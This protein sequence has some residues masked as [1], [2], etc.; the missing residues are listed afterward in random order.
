MD[1]QNMTTIRTLIAMAAAIHQPRLP[2]TDPEDGSGLTRAAAPVVVCA[3]ISSNL[4]WCSGDRTRPPR[5]LGD[6]ERDRG[7]CAVPEPDVGVEVRV[8]VVA[9]EADSKEA[10]AGVV[11]L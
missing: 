10:V 6:R 1:C 7:R 9:A 11:L 8:D 3:K 2:A 5:R 4:R